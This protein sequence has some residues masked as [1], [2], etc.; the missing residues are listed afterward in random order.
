MKIIKN[1][2]MLMAGLCTILVFM[3][4]MSVFSSGDAKADFPTKPIKVY[5]GFKPGGRTDLI[6]RMVAKHITDNKML[7]QPIVIVNKPGAAAANAARAVMAA[8]PDGH[9]I[10]HW[11]HQ[12]LIANAMSVNKI[13][14]DD[15]TTIGYTGGG[16]P[17]WTVRNDAPFNTLNDLVNTL[18]SKPRSLVEAVGIGT[19]PHLI[20]VQ[21]TAA[22]GVKTR[23]IGAGGG[24][25]RL[26]RLLGGN[27]DIAL[28]SAAGYLKHKP[29]GIKA[30]VFF[31]PNRIPSIKD[32]PTAKELG[33]NV[34][35]ANPASWLGPKG[36][37][38]EIIDKWASVLKKTIE[39]KE[40]SDWYNKRALDPYWTNGEAAL[41]DSKKVLASLKKVVIDNKIT[42]KKKK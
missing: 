36:M 13:H 34:V 29:S 26:T 33:Y 17:V 8:K 30:L 2:L 22:A 39:S 35:W 40:I 19:I 32:V 7:S 3:P 1:T 38:K 27:A 23:L 16:S 41:K 15:F 25:D 18:K 14:P 4:V 28:F 37:P 20:G 10:L 5:V 11:S 6:A 42:K 21:L 31:G 12:M 9:T 24:A